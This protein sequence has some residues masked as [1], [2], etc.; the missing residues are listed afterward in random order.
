MAQIINAS[1]RGPISQNDQ[2]SVMEFVISYTASFSP[3]E[4]SQE[5]EDAARLLEKDD[6]DNDQITP[7]QKP[8]TFLATSSAVDREFSITVL[9]EWVSGELGDEEVRGQL[10]LRRK[11]DGL[12]TDERFTANHVKCRA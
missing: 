12:P 2:H 3:N 6:T 4:L 1:I 7:Y 9:R 8:Q 11:G 10:W 5:F